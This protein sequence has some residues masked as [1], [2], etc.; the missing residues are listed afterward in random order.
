V[1]PF[2]AA[3]AGRVVLKEKVPARTW[4]AIAVAFAGIV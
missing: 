1:S 4:I 3:P 2:L